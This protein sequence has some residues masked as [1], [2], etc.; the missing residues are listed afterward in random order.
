MATSAAGPTPPDPSRPL[1]EREQ[2]ALARLAAE[3][4]REDPEWCD[5]LEAPLP[6]RHRLSPR[7][8]N[9]VIQVVV[10]V[11]LAVVLLPSA[12]V[13]VLV[14]VMVLVGPLGAALWAMRRGML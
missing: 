12:W 7:V 11:V 13:G 6:A 10:V 5:L 8:R 14:A 9:L 3:A 4:R 1:S 2:A